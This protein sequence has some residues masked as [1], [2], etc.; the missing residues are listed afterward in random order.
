MATYFLAACKGARRLT[1]IYSFA[2]SLLAVSMIMVAGASRLSGQSANASISGTVLDSSGAAVPGAAVTLTA[3]ATGKQAKFTTSVDGL[4]DFPNLQSGAYEL[5]VSAQGFGNYVQAGIILNINQQARLS[6]ELKVGSQIQTVQVSSNVSPLNFDNAEVKGTINPE[7]IASMPLIVGGNL[8]SAAAF[9][10]LMPG[11]TAPS[12]FADDARVNGG[13]HYGDDAVVDGVSLQDGAN[14][15]SGMDEALYDHPLSPESV[16]EVSVL[17]SNY[18]PRYGA[19]T[20]SIITTVTKSGTNQ[21]HGSL[22]EHLRNTALNSRQF[23]V[24]N[25]PEDLESDFGGNIGGPLTFLPGLRHFTSSARN[26]TFFFVNYEGFRIRGGASTQILTLPTTQ[27]RTGDFSDWV[28]SQG[29]LIPVYDPATTRANPNYNPAGPDMRPFLRDQ[30]MGCNGSQP[31]VICA[32][33]PRL[34]N[35]LANQWVKLLPAPT[36]AGLASNYVVPTPIP[37]STNGEGTLLEHFQ[38]KCIH[39][40]R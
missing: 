27:E 13:V 34:Q 29:N 7:T 28:D 31:N 22:Y 8:R 30:F 18:Q 39:Y 14:S 40:V 3:Q 25:R 21:Y 16:S 4:F 20:A 35:S 37:N 15:Q 23:G 17:G 38:F 33:D 2:L 9:E 36:F 19:T 11:V 26:K 1:T 32:T 6:V 10:V 12:G 5:Q 24:P